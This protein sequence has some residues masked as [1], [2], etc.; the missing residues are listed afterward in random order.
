MDC[1]HNVEFQAACP[2]NESRTV[3][4]TLITGLLVGRY[5]VFVPSTLRFVSCQADGTSS[6]DVLG[7]E[8]ALPFSC[9]AKSFS[10]LGSS[11]MVALLPLMGGGEIFYNRGI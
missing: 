1:Q 5:P 4:G 7:R 2:I 8:A 11:L 3:D 10:D 9:F 6:P